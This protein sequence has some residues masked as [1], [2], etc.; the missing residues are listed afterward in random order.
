[1]NLLAI[2]T[3]EAACSAAIW[4]DG[5]VIETYREQPRGHSELLL[6]MIDTL[7]SQSGVGKPQLDAIAFGRGPGSFTGVRIAAAVTQGISFGLDIPVIPVSSLQALAQ[8][9][10]RT[11]AHQ[12]V[13]AAFDARMNEVY[14]ALCSADAD[15]VMQLQ[16]EETVC[17]PGQ[18]S[19]PQHGRWVG[20]GSGWDAYAEAL[21]ERLSPWIYQQIPH[22]YCHAQDVAVIAAHALSQG[23][24]AVTAAQALPLYL[25]NNVAKKKAFQKT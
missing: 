22:L 16:G 9:V 7:L 24:A 11:S 15:G 20:A 19:Q 4:I 25:R 18:V 6:P 1:M 12:Q 14:W 21:T 23:D 8:G 10:H 2:E 17:A 5:E 3:S 13:A